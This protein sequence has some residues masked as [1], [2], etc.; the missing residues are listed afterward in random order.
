MAINQLN[1]QGTL[2]D[3]ISLLAPGTNLLKTAEIMQKDTPIMKDALY[4]EANNITTHTFAVRS[5]LPKSS[6]GKF[7]EPYGGERGRSKTVTIGL[8]ERINCPAYDARLVERSGNINQYLNTEAQGIMQGLAQEVDED[9]IYADKNDDFYKFDGLVRYPNATNGMLVK[10]A[11]TSSS[12]KI[13]SAYLVAWDV[14]YGAF[15]AY[16]K[17]TK[18]G[19]SIEN[20]GKRVKDYEQGKRMDVYEI[21]AGASYGL[22]VIDERAVGRIC[23]IDVSSIS[24]STFNEDKVIELVNKMPSTLRAKAVL[25]VSRGVKTAI[26]IKANSKANVWYSTDNVFGEPVRTVNGV[27]VRLDEKISE[28]EDFVS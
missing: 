28:A 10:G 2:A 24:S 19:I 23:N 22:G 8:M 9:I 12:S 25:Y 15:M 5:S 6:I 18:G 27:P 20:L 26:D 11:A 3:I 16:P 1:K 13:T 21:K 4:V 17:G 7:N 14:N